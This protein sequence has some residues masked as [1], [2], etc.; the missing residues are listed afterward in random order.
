MPLGGAGNDNYVAL[1]TR[2]YALISNFLSKSAHSPNWHV[3]HP[4][5]VHWRPTLI[6]P[7][8][9]QARQSASAILMD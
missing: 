6:G 4:R 8:W 2:N 9:C 5:F 3:S 7:S 1:G